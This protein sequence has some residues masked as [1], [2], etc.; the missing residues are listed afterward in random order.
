MVFRVKSYFLDRIHDNETNYAYS[1]VIDP[2]TKG[3]ILITTARFFLIIG[4][5]FSGK[6]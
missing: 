6:F 2:M 5:T 1:M 3:R 4:N